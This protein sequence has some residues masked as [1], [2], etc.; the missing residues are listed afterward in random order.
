[1]YFKMLII[2]LN[3]ASYK[4]SLEVDAECFGVYLLTVT[5]NGGVDWNMILAANNLLHVRVNAQLV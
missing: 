5:C 2:L 4:F 3:C 1:M